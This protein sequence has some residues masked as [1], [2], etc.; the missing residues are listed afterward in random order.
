MKTKILAG[1]LS[2][3]LGFAAVGCDDD[4][5]YSIATG[6]MVES[7]STGS[8]DVTANSA[9]LN[10]TVKGLDGASSASYAVGFNYGTSQ[11]ALTKQVDA[12]LDGQT[13]TATLTG[14]TANTTIYYQAYV[15]LQGK[16]TYTGEVKSL[17]TTDAKVVT[18]DASEVDI[19]SA[20]LA[21]SVSGAPADATLGFCIATKEDAEAVRAGLK[22]VA[23]GSASFSLVQKGLVPETE[24]FYVAYCDLGAG[25]LYGDVKSFTTKAW[26]IDADEDFVDL[27]LTTKWAK[28]NFGATSPSE[29]GGYFAFGDM[30]GVT[31]CI[32]ISQ[33]E[34][35]DINITEDIY[36]KSALDVVFAK[37][38][39]AT[40]PSA[41][42]FEELFSLCDVE[43]TTQDGVEGC[44]FTGPNGNSIFLPAAGSRTGNTISG[45]GEKGEYLT[46]SI[47]PT[48]PDFAVSYSFGNGFDSKSTSARFA[49]LAVRPV[50]VAKNIKLNKEALYGTW[51][52]DCNDA[53]ESAIWTGPIVFYNANEEGVSIDYCWQTITN[54]EP[55]EGLSVNAW[56]PSAK[57]IEGWA[58]TDWA[59]NIAYG[60]TDCYGEMTISKAEDGSDEISVSQ[61][62]KGD[63]YTYKGKVVIDEENFT[64][65]VTDMTFVPKDETQAVPEDLTIGLLVPATRTGLAH[66]TDV[67]IF[68]QQDKGFQIGLPDGGSTGQ[69]VAIN[70]VSKTEKYGWPVKLTWFDGNNDNWGGASIKLDYNNPYGQH[71]ITLNGARE[72]ASV[73]IM[74]LEGFATA[75]PDA[76]VLI[77]KIEFDGNAAQFN[78]NNF[79]YGDIENNGNYRVQ[80]HNIW[81]KGTEPVIQ[82]AFSKDGKMSEMD[83]AAKF[84]ESVCVTFTVYKKHELPINLITINPSWSG[85]W[86]TPGNQ[87]LKVVNTDGQLSTQA[88]ESV[89]CTETVGSTDYSAGSIMTF[90]EIG[91][92]SGLKGQVT[93]LKVDGNELITEDNASKVLISNEGAKWRLEAWNTYG[94]TRANGCAFG[95]PDGDVI[96]ELAFTG[97]MEFSASIE[98]SSAPF[99]NPFAE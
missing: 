30:T 44:K 57:D 90:L 53:G 40:M 86:G 36:R 72:G 67:R 65:S 79:F 38:K 89:T 1:V 16:V 45:L 24:Y 23:E 61:Y 74:D 95:T 88:V 3:A 4:D 54:N 69:Y 10:G 32:K 83:P 56:D 33:L 8:S 2:L 47:N 70:Y 80:L 43:W 93:S 94:S 37:T 19:F 7:V 82:S 22:V 87:T 39:V 92:F 11:D 12:S 6:K 14:L 20:T 48:N 64:M 29:M 75:F 50:T 34:E 71:K 9:T 27:G 21:G 49:A 78:A 98:A 68:M 42:E 15:I 59:N 5:D 41:D 55:R 66:T 63:Y 76:L 17:V 73:A 46:G 52:I 62:F 28:C 97:K 31:N 51:E 13:I 99:A 26:A 84:S 60:F 81:G 77:D 58:F 18:A 25:V 91:N 85:T 35:K 96:K